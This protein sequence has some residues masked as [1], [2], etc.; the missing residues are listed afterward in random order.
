MD[1]AGL[2]AYVISPRLHTWQTMGRQA[3]VSWTDPKPK[4]FAW[5]MLQSMSL[6]SCPPTRA[7]GGRPKCPEDLWAAWNRVGS[8]LP[9]YSFS[10]PYRCPSEQGELISSTS[11]TGFSLGQ[12]AHAHTGA[13]FPLPFGCHITRLPP[14]HPRPCWAK[15]RIATWQHAT[16]TVVT[17]LKNGGI[18]SQVLV[19]LPT[20]S[21]TP[22]QKRKKLMGTFLRWLLFLKQG[23]EPRFSMFCDMAILHD[24]F[25]QQWLFAFPSLLMGFL[26]WWHFPLS[27]SST[28]L[29]AAAIC[30]LSPQLSKGKSTQTPNIYSVPCIIITHPWP[31]STNPFPLI[32]LL[33]TDGTWFLEVMLCQKVSRTTS[34]RY[35]PGKWSQDAAGWV[36]GLGQKKNM[37]VGIP[38][39]SLNFGN[40]TTAP[41]LTRAWGLVLTI[42]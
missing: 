42:A 32:C 28:P 13:S 1:K 2:R 18:P 12:A 14:P 3:D 19:R 35:K 39:Q 24:S 17:A 15:G 22:S 27:F 5:H 29:N 33:Q 8:L 37:D 34:L 4:L 26:F 10:F 6:S 31:S 38:G 41:L 36:E 40:E 9:A 25:C 11:S 30:L 7:A 23:S 16:R 21:S 20:A